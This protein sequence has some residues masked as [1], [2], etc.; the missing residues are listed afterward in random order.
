M[1]RIAKAYPEA[2]FEPVGGKGGY[3]LPCQLAWK[4][5]ET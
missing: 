3:L 4:M 5:E 2:M 1:L